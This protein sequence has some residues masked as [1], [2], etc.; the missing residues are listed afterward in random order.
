MRTGVAEKYSMIKT[1][2]VLKCLV[3]ILDY[4]LIALRKKELQL[5]FKPDSPHCNYFFGTLGELYM[6]VNI[7]K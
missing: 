7:H 2:N 1:E 3:N 5:D 4:Q 6:N